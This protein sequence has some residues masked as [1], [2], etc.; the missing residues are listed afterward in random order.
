[1]KFISIHYTLL[2]RCVKQVEVSDDFKIRGVK[3]QKV[4]EELCRKL[5]TENLKEIEEAEAY[6]FESQ[7]FCQIDG[8]VL[9][10]ETKGVI[11]EYVENKV[12]TIDLK[13]RSA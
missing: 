11:K 6:D 5:P 2:T 12:F 10:D 9:L 13:R 7:D 1:M 3:T 4:Y 8:I